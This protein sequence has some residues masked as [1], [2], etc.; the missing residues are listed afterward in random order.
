MFT[1]EDSSHISTQSI[2]AAQRPQIL[3]KNL[4]PKRAANSSCS[5][6]AFSPPSGMVGTAQGLTA[7]ATPATAGKQGKDRY[8]P[9]Q[10]LGKTASQAAPSP[11]E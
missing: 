9:A 3:I 6:L 5:L 2:L 7:L 4:L 8:F 1:Y 11:S 10:S